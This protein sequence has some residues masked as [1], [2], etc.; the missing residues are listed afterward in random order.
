M[1]L[2]TAQY[3]YAG[4]DRL[5]ITVKG[6]DPVGKIFAPTWKMVMGTK[7]GNISW[8][9]YKEMYRELMRESY[10]RSSHI[11]EEVLSR[12]QL[13]LVCF[14]KDGDLCH[15]YLLAEFL[16]KLGA[17]YIGERIL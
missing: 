5:D 1:K 7:S 11:W 13:T 2:Y 14:C 15:R 6:N 3:K 4:D 10:R 12:K 8:D 17:E 16:A 9:D